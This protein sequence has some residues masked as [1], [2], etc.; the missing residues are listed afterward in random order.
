MSATGKAKTTEEQMPHW[1]SMTERDF[2]YA[3]DLQGK[4][5]TLTV[6]KV[7]GGEL[8]GQ[9]GKKTKKPLCYFVES[10]SGKP[11]ALNAT[12]CKTIAAMY[13]ND[14]DN[15]LGKRITLFPTT[16]S[17]GSETVECI[18]VR[19]QVPPDKKAKSE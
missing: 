7:T 5:C 9:G 3:F 11:L 14:T 4:D 17:F 10:K 15:W 19:P 18:R 1:K 2:L 16:T 8:T 13:G 6:E 12:N